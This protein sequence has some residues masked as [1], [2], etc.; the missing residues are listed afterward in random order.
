MNPPSP[1]FRQGVSRLARK[2]RESAEASAHAPAVRLVAYRRGELSEAD[3]A[4]LAEHLSICPAC[5]SELLE[6]AEFLDDEGEE[7]EGETE[8]AGRL[9]SRIEPEI[10]PV[11]EL[12]ERPAEPA[13]RSTLRPPGSLRPPRPARS[14]FRS[15]PAAYALAAAFAALSLGLILFG[16][17]AV[18]DLSPRLNEGLYD[19]SD[20]GTERGPAEAGGETAIEFAAGSD[21]ATLI[22]NPTRPADPA[23]RYGVRFLR[24]DG[25]VAWEARQGLV[26]RPLGTFQIGISRETFP[27]GRYTVELFETRD[28]GERPLGRFP[29][30]IGR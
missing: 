9:W 28:E 2:E 18:P 24:A 10:R 13:M 16:R 27:E 29:V 8:T 4:A 12:E 17:G 15:L 6:I 21:S 23:G 30:S 1:T 14:I 22:L 3:A 20:R 5:A 26:P 11:E 25:G 7:G 19:L